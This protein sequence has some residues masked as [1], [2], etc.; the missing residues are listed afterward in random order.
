MS[1]VD[2]GDFVNLT[3]RTAGPHH[4]QAVIVE[5]P[6]L[7]AAP[8]AG[9][10]VHGRGATAESILDLAH[11]IRAPHVTWLAPQ[12]AAHS[13]YPNRFLAPLASN[14]PWLSSALAAVGDLVSRAMEAGIARDR[15]F[16]AGFSQGACLTLEFIVR[17]ASRYG[18]VAGLSG[19]LI[20]PPGTTWPSVGGLDRTPV[21]LGCSDIDDHIPA[22]RVLESADVL[23]ANGAEV[24]DVL[25][26]GMG[27]TVNQDE[28]KHVQR[29]IDRLA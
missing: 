10:L 7:G 18:G 5:G 25:Y 22:A 26:P 27:H 8:V 11:A 17:N 28:L 4:G 16:L 9:I 24:T 20:G 12:A 14:E 6:P 21:F 1:S 3:L 19:G 29:L 13:W 15:V 23:R 2:R